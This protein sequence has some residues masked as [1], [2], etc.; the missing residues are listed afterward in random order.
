M[1]LRQTIYRLLS[2]QSAKRTLAST[3]VALLLSAG[4]ASP[5][6]AQDPVGV[7]G[8]EVVETVISDE[9][10]I[11]D[12]ANGQILPGPGGG[13]GIIIIE[14]TPM[15]G[16]IISE[17]VVE[18]TVASDDAVSVQGEVVVENDDA[19]TP[20]SSSDSSET[21]K[22]PES[23]FP[24]PRSFAKEVAAA[25]ENI[26]ATVAKGPYAASW[27][28]L[29]KYEIP[30]WYEDAKFGI[31]IHWGAY[32]VPAHGSEWYP[33]NMYIDAKNKGESIFE[34]HKERFG[35]QSTF[36]YKDF[37]KDFKAENFDAD[38]WAQLFADCGARY[39]VP[40]A[41][42]HDGFPMYDCSFS[43]WTATRMG[44]K[45]DVIA[46]LEKSV[47]AKGLK[48]GVS[49]HRAF[50]WIFYVRDKNFDNADPAYEGLYGRALD[51][52]FEEDASNYQK[53]WPP[54][55][56]EFKDDWLARTCEL[57]DKYNADLIWFDFGIAND[58]KKTYEENAFADHLKKFAAYYYNNAASKGGEVP[59][60]NYKWQAFPEK[61]AVLDLERNKMADIRYPFWQTD[62][63]VSKSSWG[64]TDNQ[65]YKQPNRLVDDLIDI[66]SKNGCLL[67][68]VGP[69]PDGTIPEE[70]QAILLEIGK[71]LKV[72]GE[73]IYETRP[74][75][76]F[77][78]GPTGTAT[79]HLAEDKDKPFTEKDIRFT[80][81]GDTLYVIALDW[82]KDG[83][84]NVTSLPAGNAH[85]P[86]AFESIELIGSDA[87]I[88][89]EQTD[90]GLMIKM[91]ETKPCDHAFVFKLK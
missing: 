65:K 34:Y 7:E 24:A 31:F 69:R 39:V 89:M 33:R 80:T 42:H 72:N 12:E 87:N 67:L 36:G 66:V 25:I 47:R 76:I 26:D 23:E 59:I 70:D 54:Q 6:F 50:N 63:A 44:P 15:E 58:K 61:A 9:P 27:D 91:P 84:L 1:T 13:G 18:D 10:V 73:A 8:T 43:D 53:N 51:S 57:A 11:V 77:G 21:E 86:K 64:Y 38:A 46:E 45:R 4:V 40:V 5:L 48:F 55:D 30:K 37:L 75:K 16:A 83:T 82:P 19:V 56:Q 60:I 52:L 62:T 29:E 17:T 90:A 71:W 78:E 35:D 81:K 20:S 14:E 49:S 2:C 41:E 74:F 68:N 32:S 28:S 22:A 3:S 85:H 88:E 79:G